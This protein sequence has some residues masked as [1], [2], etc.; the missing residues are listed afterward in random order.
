MGGVRMKKGFKTELGL[1][2]ALG[3]SPLAHADITFTVSTLVDGVDSNPGDSICQ[4]ASNA[5]SLRAAVQEANLHDGITTINL[6]IDGVYTLGEGVADTD[7]DEQNPIDDSA[8]DLDII[9]GKT[10]IINGTGS[11]VSAIDGMREE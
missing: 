6:Q 1:A 7:G 2:L 11:R 9:N 8:G 4:T 5:C 3:L 10:V